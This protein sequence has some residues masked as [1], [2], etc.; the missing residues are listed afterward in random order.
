MSQSAE[1]SKNLR[2]DVR[3]LSEANGLSVEEAFFQ[4]VSDTITGSGEVDALE[5]FHH[6]GSA[7]SGIRIDGWGGNPKKTKE[8]A[9]FV[10]DYTDDLDAPTLTATELNLLFKRPL[11]FLK[12]ALNEEWR[13][14]LEETSPGH[15][16]A[17]MI[18]SYWANVAK[19]RLILITD[20]KLSNRV[21]G[22]DMTDFLDRRVSY[23]VWDVTRL[24]RI[25]GSAV[26]REDIIVDLDEYGGAVPVLAAHMSDSPYESYLAALPG[27]TLAAIYDRWQARLLEQN[28][29]VFLQAKGNVNKAIKKTIEETPSMFFAYNNGITATAEAIE[30]EER[31]GTMVMT[32][33]TNLQIVNGGQTSASIHA[34]LLNKTSLSKI[35]VQMKLSIVNSEQ[36][37]KMVP[38]IARYA[39]SQNKIDPADFF[40]NHQFHIRMEEISRRIF[41]PAKD[42]SFTQSRWFYE[43]ARGQF[44]DKKTQLSPAQKKK[45]DLEHPRAQL[46][47]KTDLAKAE[48]AW[49]MSP[50]IVCLGAQK[51]FVHFAHA[52]GKQWETNDKTF[53]EEWFKDAI[54][55]L[56]VFRKTERIVSDA[57]ASWYTG[58]L[59]AQTVCYTISKFIYDMTEAGKSLDLR[60]I[61]GDQEL[62]TQLIDVLDRYA[63]A[64]HTHLL[65][66]PTGSSNPSEWAK[67]KPCADAAM[68]LNLDFLDGISDIVINSSER[69]SREREGRQDQELVNGIQARSDAATF[70]AANWVKLKEWVLKNNIRLTPSEVRILESATRVKLKP[71]SETQAI[72]AMAVLGRAEEAG[73]VKNSN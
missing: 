50:E 37:T 16:L 22:R 59:R 19:I 7:Q 53:S 67:K 64:M 34:A 47:S 60:K 23:S 73:Y 17:Q 5:Y 36:A 54:V 46:F 4:R 18:D 1:F 45:F 21:D 43:R 62:P 30:T 66:P 13:D 38:D 26:G 2:E 24:E 41:A 10:M 6:R 49:R 25:E 51:N 42:G 32:R 35:F 27:T 11:R 14:A 72:K 52:I 56:I 33:L 57:A 20:R 48:M 55:K 39:N 29:R 69:R 8:L 28:V 3:L 68:S 44:A 71:L 9:L 12:S 31:L 40:S 15:E 65:Y 63:E 70:G 61:W 58:G